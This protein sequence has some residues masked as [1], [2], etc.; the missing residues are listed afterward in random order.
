M[1]LS[2]GRVVT[3]QLLEQLA[4]LTVDLGRELHLDLDQVVAPRYGI[5][6]F[7]HTLTCPWI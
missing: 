2:L 6:Q 7:R 5:A 1:L 4:L 3:R